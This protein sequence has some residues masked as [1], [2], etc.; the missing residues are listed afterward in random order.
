LTRRFTG[1]TPAISVF[2]LI[3]FGLFCAALYSG[4]NLLLGA[5]FGLILT[6]VII[7]AKPPIG[8]ALA[9]V[10]LTVPLGTLATLP[11]AWGGV[12][13]V[14]S[15]LAAIG[16]GLILLARGGRIP[17]VDLAAGVFV[18]ATSFVSSAFAANS[19]LSLAACKT[20]VLSMVV[21]WSA[22]AVYTTSSRNLANVV[23]TAAGAMAAI[24]S[25]LVLRQTGSEGLALGMIVDK[26]ESDLSFGRSNY[27]ASLITLGALAII[28]VVAQARSRSRRA[29]GAGIV[30]LAGVGIIAAGSRSQ[31]V[32]IVVCVPLALLASLWDR[33]H[34][35]S[36]IGRVIGWS[37]IAGGALWF[38]SPYIA[39]IWAPVLEHN[40]VGFSTFEQ[41]LTI[42]R[43]TWDSILA[44]PLFGVGLQNLTMPDGTYTMAHNWILQV[45]AEVGVVGL[46]AYLLLVR[47]SLVGV[48]RGSRHWIVFFLIA[49]CV[50]GMAEPTLRTREYDYVCWA[51]LGAIS[52]SCARLSKSSNHDRATVTTKVGDAV[53]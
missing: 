48:P 22:R 19:L 30:L 36:R 20:V 13:V 6:V 34:N 52:A 33:G 42:W 21:Y 45:Q 11:R 8:L 10:P 4:S 37:V 35:A 38:A 2:L 7:L 27:L 16:C 3:P 24:I 18:L 51:V 32:A 44:H 28:P 17:R 26:S 31:I 23:G 53:P 15:D 12:P 49:V 47:S 46:V 25:L 14:Y 43:A 5:S 41:R 50:A 40:V 29:V 9:L 1:T 39:R